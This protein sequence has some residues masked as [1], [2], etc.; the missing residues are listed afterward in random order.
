[1]KLNRLQTERESIHSSFKQL[2][3]SKEF[4][5]KKRI[6]WLKI[7]SHFKVWEIENPNK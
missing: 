3:Q 6:F 5:K 4:S 2:N 7:C 1:M